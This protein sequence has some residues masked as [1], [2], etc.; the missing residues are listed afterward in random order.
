VP[1]FAEVFAQPGEWRELLARLPA[2]GLFN[3][4][5]ATLELLTRI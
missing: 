4:D 5:D 3:V 2:A 1:L